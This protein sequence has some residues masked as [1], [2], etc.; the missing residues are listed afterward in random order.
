LGARPATDEDCDGHLRDDDI[1]I[2]QLP[3][4]PSFYCFVHTNWIY[5]TKDDAFLKFAP[6]SNEVSP[7][8]IGFLTRGW[9]LN[10]MYIQ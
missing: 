9:H 3:Y 5:M 10:I 4:V 8:P 7:T 6:L 1:V 2:A